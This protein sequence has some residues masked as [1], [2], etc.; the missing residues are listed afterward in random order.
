M[1]VW[2]TAPVERME[3][4]VLMLRRLGVLTL[5]AT[6]VAAFALAGDT[7]QASGT[8]KSVEQNSFTVTDNNAKDWSFAVDK[9]TLV[10]AKGASHKMDKLKDNGKLP[11]IDEF[12]S[13]N[14]KVVVK[15]AEKDGKM[16]V[17]EVRIQDAM[18]K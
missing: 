5:A 2:H 17:K 10:L 7:K 15:Y 14:Q 6:F 9:D 16:V 12:V 13:A 8:V 3:E 11:T 1:V 18:V 4:V